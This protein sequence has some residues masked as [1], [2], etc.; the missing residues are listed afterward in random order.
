MRL[1]IRQ[2]APVRPATPEPSHNLDHFSWSQMSMYMRCSMQYYFRYVKGFKMPPGLPL[3]IG[4]GGHAALEW[5]ARKKMEGGTD[6]PL[7]DLQD[8]TSDFLD[9]EINEL[10]S[11]ET[12]GAGKAKDDAIMMVTHFRVKQAPK[13]TPIA[14]EH[15]F[16]IIIPPDDEHPDPTKPVLGFID[17]AAEIERPGS[18]PGQSAKVIAIEDYKF[19]RRKKSQADV[20]LLPQITLYDYVFNE[21]VGQATD[22]IGLRQFQFTKDGPQVTPIYRSKEYMAPGVR[23]IRWTRLKQQIRR[24]QHAIKAGVFFPTDNPQTCAWCGFLPICQFSPIKTK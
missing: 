9:S 8:L 15:R 22:V 11:E 16:E 1:P 23:E 10:P 6:M 12:S 5:N 4:K 18:H 17:V 19:A 24:I 20:D 14:I 3:A 21:Q 7:S 2:A 13:I